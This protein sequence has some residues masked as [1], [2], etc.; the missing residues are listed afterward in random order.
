MK[1]LQQVALTGLIF[2]AGCPAAVLAQDETIPLFDGPRGASCAYFNISGFVKWRHKKGDWKDVN[3]VPQGPTPFA[4]ATIE[5][6]D[7]SRVV[8]WNITSLAHAWLRSRS[9]GGGL[10]L[11]AVPGHA[12]GDIFFHSREADDA[13]VRPRLVLEFADRSSR[14][15]APDADAHLDCSTAYGLGKEKL[16]HAGPDTSVVMQFPLEPR[17]RDADLLRAT[18]QLTTTSKQYGNAVIGVYELDS[19][20]KAA[21]GQ[22][23]LGIAN[24]FPWDRGIEKHPDVLM[25]TGFDS[26]LWSRDWSDVRHPIP[27]PVASDDALEFEP[28]AGKALRVK[29]P[30]GGNIGLDMDYAFKDK[31]GEEPEEIYFRYYL[32]F[33]SDWL[34]TVE[35]GKLPGVSGTYGRAGWGGRK[36]NGQNGWSMRGVFARM[37]EEG[38]PLRNYIVVGTYA[39]HAD[40][41]GIYGDDWIW[42]L[43][44]R[45]LLRRNQWYCIEQYFRLNHV[46]AKDGELKAWIDGELAIDHTGFR[47]RD[48]PDIRIEKIWMNVYHGGVTPSPTD[49][50]RYIDNVVIA[51]RY[52]GPMRRD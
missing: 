31:T 48:V 32:R 19:P 24:E 36:T 27:S 7:L 18:L 35:G 1:I 45:G 37:P 41:E 33:A 49:L 17:I 2:A 43:G 14:T 51:R 21:R 9:V 23:Q 28:L 46:G 42:D 52:I 22:P 50:H 38:N 13:R 47:V 40:T 39:Y 5:S 10:L 16:L 11:A 26:L 6:K 8:E 15:L 44:L 30:T 25:A 20:Q 3:G 12:Q 4:S 34:P 29:I